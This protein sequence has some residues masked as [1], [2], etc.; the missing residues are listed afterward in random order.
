MYEV[1]G[2][3]SVIICFYITFTQKCHLFKSI[4]DPVSEVRQHNTLS[5]LTVGCVC[6]GGGGVLFNNMTIIANYY[7]K[8]RIISI[9]IDKCLVNMYKLV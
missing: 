5:M 7:I 3:L 6:V 8:V 4:Q 2:N 1:L 9:S